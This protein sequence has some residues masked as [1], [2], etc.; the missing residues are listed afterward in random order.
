[1]TVGMWLV[2]NRMSMGKIEKKNRHGGHLVFL[3]EPKIN[4]N[5]GIDVRKVLTKCSEDPGRIVLDICC[6]KESD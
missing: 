6:K 5:E 4:R 3:N 2:S 1:M